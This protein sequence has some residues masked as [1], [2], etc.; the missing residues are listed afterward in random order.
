MTF[1][2]NLDLDQSERKG[3]PFQVEARLSGLSKRVQHRI[4][5]HDWDSDLEHSLRLAGDQRL[6]LWRSPDQPVE[7]HLPAQSRASATRHR[8]ADVVKADLHCATASPGPH[9]VPACNRRQI[10]GTAQAPSGCSHQFQG[11]RPLPVS[12][13]QR[14]PRALLETQ[15][16]VHHRGRPASNL[17]FFLLLLPLP[18]ELTT[19]ESP[20]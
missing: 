7:N 17:Q 6:L 2:R 18:H 9:R 12:P 8:Q 16:V 4:M 11:L 5:E 10:R 3:A 20:G 19:S 14:A 1:R 13:I 15:C